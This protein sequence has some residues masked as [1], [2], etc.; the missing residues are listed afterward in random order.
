MSIRLAKRKKFYT[1][2]SLD[3][4]VVGYLDELA[5]EMGMPRSLALNFLLREHARRHRQ[6]V[7][8]AV[9]EIA[10]EAQS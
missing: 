3:R 9:V 7:S 4:E 5:R 8:A 6:D 2:V 1:G 10:K